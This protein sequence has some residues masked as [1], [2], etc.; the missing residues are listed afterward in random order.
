MSFSGDV[1]E[2]G[3]RLVALI[4]A[5]ILV[6]D[7]AVALG[8]P[9][10]RC[11]AILRAVGRPAGKPRGPSRP[12]N[13]ALIKATFTETDLV[14]HAAKATEVS[15]TV[16]RRILLEAGQILVGKPEARRRFLAL[17]ADGWSI[18]DAAAEVGVN[19]RTA[20]DWRDG[21]RRA[22]PGRIHSDGT[23]VDYVRG[24][25]YKSAVTKIDSDGPA[26]TGDRYLS[27]QNRLDI[28]DG[29]VTGQSL[30]VIAARIGK[31]KS[32]VSREVRAHQVNGCY[33][34]YQANQDA[35]AARQRPKHAKLVANRA[36]RAAVIEGLSCQRSPEQ[37]SH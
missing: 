19:V 7:A 16:A 37:I 22:G 4:E 26:S 5:G 36:L 30:T 1:A 3:D 34:P 28:A 27:L 23:V 20:R 25:R 33:L 21:I 18:G 14:A 32:T 9:R 15:F 12:Q 17:I 2:F 24:T 29:L 11:Y 10:D 13:R 35:S 6:A 8:I 31:H